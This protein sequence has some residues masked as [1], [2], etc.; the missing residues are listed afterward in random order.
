MIG[1]TMDETMTGTHAFSDGSYEGRQLPLSF[2]LTWGSSNLTEF[3]NP[4]S[5]G[6]FTSTANGFITVGGLADKA[7]CTGKL[8][9]MYFSKRKIRY[10]LDFTGDNSKAYKYVGEKL[11]LWP[12]NLHKTHF[13]CYGTITDIEA[14]KIISSS[15]VYFPYRQLI[16]FLMSAR[17][18]KS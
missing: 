13:T 12:W 1:F 5:P 2:F 6:F 7:D 14:G 18:V 17:L 3:L 9:L 8:E 4:F 15:I 16:D 10:E 11:N